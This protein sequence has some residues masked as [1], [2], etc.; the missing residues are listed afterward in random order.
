MRAFDGGFRLMVTALAL[1]LALGGCA[2]GDGEE[3]ASQE[4]PHNVRVLELGASTLTEYFEIAG[5]VTP[6]RAADLSAEESGP[7]VA[8]GVD[9]GGAVAEGELIVEQERDILA[10]ELAAAEADLQA[11]AY[12]V[13]KVRQ[14]YDAGKVSRMELL[15]AESAHARARAGAEVSAVRHARAAISAPFAGVVVDR[16]V[17]LGELV[18]PGR[19]VARVIDPYT[20]KIEAFLTDTQVGWVGRGDKARVVLGESGPVTVGTV[21]FIAPEASR[22]TGKFAVEIDIANDELRYRSGV[23]GRA[24]LPKHAT[25]GAVAVPRD[26]VLEGRAGPTAYVVEDDRAHLRQLELGSFQGLMVIV[27]SGLEPGDRLV[28]RGQRDLREGALVQ[29]TET[30]TAADGSLA[31]DPAAVTAAGAGTRV[32]ADAD[33]TGE[34]RR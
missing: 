21:T 11:Q 30:A 8:L 32:R 33:G 12:N 28:V 24:Q 2:A 10:A 7:V 23:I 18:P 9:K 3:R 13:D 4:V 22:T 14:L 1:G 29:V 5:P 16:Y 26:A 27:E 6:V 19:L 25:E 34:A 31:D 15:N 20:L 17:E